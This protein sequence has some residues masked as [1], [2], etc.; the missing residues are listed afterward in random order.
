[1]ALA[2]PAASSAPLL[3]LEREFKAPP[4]RV[5]AAWTDPRLM[6]RWW[7]PEGMT[8]PVCEVDLRVGGRYRT[9]MK[10][11][12]GDEHWVSGAYRE[13]VPG[14]RLAFTWAWEENGVRG[15]EMLVE[16]EFVPAGRHTRL[17]MTQSN[18]ASAESR[19]NHGKGW[20]S[21]FV[22]LDQF[23]AGE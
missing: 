18:F 5:F 10:G 4:E 13:I 3:R 21:S 14:K 22:C 9:C 6:A 19:D 12:K 17:V 15:H 7:G 16:V 1:M 2:A 8:C 23:L 20:T 11:E